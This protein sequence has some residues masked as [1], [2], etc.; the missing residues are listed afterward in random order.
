MYKNTLLKWSREARKG[1][2]MKCISVDVLLQNMKDYN[3][4]NNN[5]IIEELSFEM[6]PLLSYFY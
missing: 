1:Y 4:F 6:I 3:V 2:N 5:R